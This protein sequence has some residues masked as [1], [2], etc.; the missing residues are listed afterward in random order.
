MLDTSQEGLLNFNWEDTEDNFFGLG[1]PT[2]ASP[3]K[4]EKEKEEE[5]PESKS[6]E[7]EEEEEEKELDFFSPNEEEQEEQEEE[8][9][10]KHKTSSKTSTSIY[11]DVYKDLRE[12]G[13]FKHAEIEEGE[14]LD[15]DKLFELQQQEYEAEVSARLTSWATEELDEDARAFI[16]FKRDGGSTE[17]FLNTYSKSSALPTGDISDESYQDRIIRFQL[18]Q[19]GWDS[20]EVEDRLKY[21]TDS[22]T[23][24]R[25]AKRYD[26]KIREEADREK[27]ATL[28]QAA[29]DRE[30]IEEQEKEYKKTIRTVLT[31]TKDV[32]GVK[33]TDKD[34]TELF[35]FLTKKDFKVSDTKSITGF[36]KKLGEVFQDTSK[37]IL[38]AK[39]V[40]SDFD[41][42]DFEKASITKKTKQIKSNLEQRK[43]LRPTSSGSSLGGNSLAELF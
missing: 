30:A 5:A 17:D 7:K 4:E 25:V 36:Q 16:K 12:Q 9:Q 33:I 29:R 3:K 27:A 19:E 35:N 31:D 41:M 22:G 39:L 15:A 6:K 32:N 8:G 26:N 42:K 28:A 1:N 38:L 34:K 20:E 10:E 21:L 14:D 23:K 43:G 2:P 11:T 40:N 13:I 37:M 24:Q 18:K